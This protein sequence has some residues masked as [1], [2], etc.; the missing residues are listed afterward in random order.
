MS[1]DM[2]LWSKFFCEA[3]TSLSLDHEHHSFFDLTTSNQIQEFWERESFLF[4]F[5]PVAK[6]QSPIITMLLNNAHC[7][8][9]RSNA[10][11]HSSNVVDHGHTDSNTGSKQAKDTVGSGQQPATHLTPPHRGKAGH[12][13]SGP[14]MDAIPDTVTAN[15]ILSNNPNTG[16]LQGMSH[17]GSGQQTATCPHLPCMSEL[18]IS[19]SH[20]SAAGS[21][22]SCHPTGIAQSNAGT[23]DPH[24]GSSQSAGNSGSGHQTATYPC[25]SCMS[26]EGISASHSGTAGSSASCHPTGT[27][28][29]NT[30]TTNS[31][32]SS[33]SS[34]QPLHLSKLGVVINLSSHGK[35]D[36][37]SGCI[38]DSDQG[39]AI[40]HSLK[41]QDFINLDSPN[42]S[43]TPGLFTKSGWLQAKPVTKPPS[44]A[45]A[46]R[47]T[48]FHKQLHDFIMDDDSCQI[49]TGMQYKHLHQNQWT[50]CP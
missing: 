4:S 3:Q 9:S 39:L 36:Q 29:P 27:A 35:Y 42:L 47:D 45:N 43:I 32:I 38:I 22:A 33:T 44:E 25:S 26:E 6:T 10:G 30:S 17:L 2:R 28:Q 40:L 8:S 31:M 13:A 14:N 5:H 15:T 20:S 7:H 46:T 12:S 18:G 24:T 23:T 49:K 50:C 41:L 19:A 48:H 34:S 11:K 21:S 37:P 1:R 16:S